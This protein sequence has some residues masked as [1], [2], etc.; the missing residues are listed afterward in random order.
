MAKAN[1]PLTDDEIRELLSATLHGPLPTATMHRVFATLADV[2]RLRV[3]ETKAKE[4]LALVDRLVT[5]G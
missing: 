2:P 3:V 1:E 4:A 5:R